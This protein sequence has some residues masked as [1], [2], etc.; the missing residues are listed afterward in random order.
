VQGFPS[1]QNWNVVHRRNKRLPPVALAFK[2]F[3]LADGAT[4]IEEI[5]RVRHR[6]KGKGSAIRIA[7][8]RV[9]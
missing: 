1:M 2:S 7:R 3:L 5:T 8:S 9:S 6:P 4:Q